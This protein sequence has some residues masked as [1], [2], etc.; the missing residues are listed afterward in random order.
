MTGRSSSHPLRG[1]ELR[2]VTGDPPLDDAGR[3]SASVLFF[4][5]ARQ[6]EHA[7]HEGHVD[8]LGLEGPAARLIGRD[9]HPTSSRPKSR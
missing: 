7:A 4:V 1:R 2:G 3:R 9:L 6:I 8:R 5:F